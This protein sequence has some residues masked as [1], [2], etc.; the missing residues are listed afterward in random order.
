[1]LARRDLSEAQLR[2]RLDRRGYDAH[3]RRVASTIARRETAL[4][5]HGRHRVQRQLEAAGIAPGIVR[6][7]IDEAFGNVSEDA[8]LERLLDRRVKG[9]TDV[10]EPRERARLYRYLIGQG[11][12]AEH[13]MRALR[14]RR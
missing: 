8:L 3:D 6:T 11:F 13:V 2:Q 12:D 7:A 4:K 1:M 10:I 5:G 9:R 14:K